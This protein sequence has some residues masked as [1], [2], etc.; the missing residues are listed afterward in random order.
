MLKLCGS[1]V[2]GIYLT[3]V[4]A[5]VIKVFGWEND[6]VREKYAVYQQNEPN[7]MG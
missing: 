4:N 7:C 1:T 5:I 6:V 3:T 2:N